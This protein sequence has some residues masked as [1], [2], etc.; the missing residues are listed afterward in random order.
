MERGFNMT[1]RSYQEQERNRVRKAQDRNARPILRMEILDGVF[2]VIGQTVSGST[3]HEKF[4]TQDEA[5]RFAKNLKE[6][7]LV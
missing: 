2:H 6:G 3:F 1:K 7:G 4:E 5:A